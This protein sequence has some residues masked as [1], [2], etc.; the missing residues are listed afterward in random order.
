M[1]TSVAR[2][3]QL[4]ETIREVFFL[5]DPQMEMFY[6]SPAICRNPSSRMNLAQRNGRQWSASLSYNE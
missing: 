4:A 5:T 6:V 3:R 1:L 2:F